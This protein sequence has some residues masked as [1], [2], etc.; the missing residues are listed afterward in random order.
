MEQRKT[1]GRALRAI[2]KAKGISQDELAIAGDMSPSHLHRI[3]T[4]DRQPNQD[5]LNLMCLHLGIS[6]EDV[7]YEVETL[8]LVSDPAH[9]KLVK[10][11]GRVKVNA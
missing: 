7:T 3:E 4:G 10:N 11:A 9:A 1:H 6:T 5:S 8:I 2:R